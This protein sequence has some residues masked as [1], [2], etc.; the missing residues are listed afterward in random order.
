MKRSITTIAALLLLLTL[1]AYAQKGYPRILYVT[2]DGALV[3][4][5]TSYLSS[6]LG[7]LRRGDSVSALASEKKFF[8]ISFGGREGYVLGSNLSEKKPALGKKEGATKRAPTIDAGEKVIADSVRGVDRS[9]IA[10]SLARR[11]DAAHKSDDTERRKRESGEGAQTTEGKRSESKE[12]QSGSAKESSQ[13][14]RATTKSGKRCSRM[15]IDRSG[16]CWQHKE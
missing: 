7:E 12:E 10:D 11:P 13:Q 2:Y 9:R 8:R 16:F 14:C 15:T 3:Y 5:S 1:A 6:V 4:D